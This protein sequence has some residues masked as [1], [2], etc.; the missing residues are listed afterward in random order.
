M[1]KKLNS[2]IVIAAIML[3]SVSSFGQE[4]SSKVKTE[5]FEVDGVCGM[6]KDRIENAALIKGVK[7]ATWDKETQMLKV[8]YKPSKVS[9][10]EIHE[11]VA[12]AGHETKKAKANMDAYNKL[13][14]CCKYKDGAVKH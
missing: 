13:P 9:I 5:S 14:D 7:L 12:E 4:E 2:I 10:Q 3:I 11:A 8:V 1:K 6:C